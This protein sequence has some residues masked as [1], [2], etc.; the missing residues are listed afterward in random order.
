[1][2]RLFYGHV[3]TN[4][5]KIH[6]Y[7]T[8]D[9]KPPVVF[10]HGF[11]DNG[12]CWSRIAYLLEPFYDIILVDARGHGL[13][14]ATEDGYTPQDRAADVAGLI[15][16][17]HLGTPHLVGHSMGADTAVFTAA[18]YPNLVG[19]LILEDPPFWKD[20]G[21]ETNESRLHRAE[22]FQRQILEQREKSLDEL[23]EIGKSEHPDWD[24]ADL[25]QWGKAKQQVRIQALK[26][27]NEHREPWQF[28]AREVKC[29]VLLITGDPARGAIVTPEVAEE[30]GKMWRK[31]E[32]VQI[33]GAGHNIRRDNFELFYQAVKQFL[34]K[35]T[36][37]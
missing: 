15:Q 24:Q 23:I 20:E 14:E 8:G 21:K 34:R 17:L 37:W 13:S 31:S 32:L 29:P 22:R 6:Y 3:N 16:Y 26:S 2:A 4:G 5:A 12:L 11:S 18:M 36:K 19:G 1:M 30:A 25:F 9:E 27:V 35:Q 33:P 7:R 28:Y 10:L